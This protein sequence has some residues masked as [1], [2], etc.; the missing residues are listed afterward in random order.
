MSYGL[1]NIVVILVMNGCYKALNN[2]EKK[3]YLHSPLHADTLSL[4]L[5]NADECE[6]TQNLKP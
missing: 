5:S 3:V 1:K 6:P 2:E 4:V